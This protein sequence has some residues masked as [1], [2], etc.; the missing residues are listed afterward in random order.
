MKDLR[1][2]LHVVLHDREDFCHKMLHL[3]S[4]TEILY[5]VTHQ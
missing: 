2:F 5:K 4:M 3:P 1:G